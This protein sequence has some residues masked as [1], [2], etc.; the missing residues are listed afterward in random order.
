MRPGGF[1]GIIMLMKFADIV[2]DIT[3]K[4]VDRPFTYIIPEE[5]EEAVVPG[6]R[7]NVP[8]GRGNAL[9][10]GYVIG[11]KSRSALPEEKLKGI[12][13]LTEKAVGIDEELV[14]L[15][16]WLRYRYGGTLY[17]AL[18]VCTMSRMKVEVRKERLLVFTGT[19]DQLRDQ[20]YKASLKKYKARERLLNAFLEN[21]VIPASLASDRLS[22]SASTLRPLLQSGLVVYRTVDTDAA[23]DGDAGA[24]GN[25][26]RP[27]DAPELNG[28]QKEAVRTVLTSEK[29]VSV[30]FGITGS[31]KTEV[32][33]ELIARCLEAGKE[34]IVLIPEIALT[35]QTVMRFYRRFGNLIS[36]VHS[37]LS[38]GEKYERFEAAREGKIRVMIGPRSALFTP[39]KNLG[40]IVI[41]EFHETAYQSETVP[42]YD[43]VETAIKRASFSDAR[44]LLGSATPPAEYYERALRGEF[45]LI[46]LTER[47]VRGAVLPKVQLVDMREELKKKNRSIFSEALREKIREKLDRKEQIMLFLNRRGYSGAVSC[48]ACGLPVTCPHCSIALS[49]H[50][51]GWLQCHICGFSMPMVK[52]CPECGSGLIGTFGIGTEK[53]EEMVQEAFPDASVL[54]MDADT[55]TGKNGHQEIIRKFQEQ[56]ADILIGTQMIVK[57][58]D[59]KKVTLMGILAADLSLNVPDYRSAERTFQLLVQAEGRAGRDEIPGDC[60][61]QT[62]LPEHYAIQAAA[63]QDY[64]SFFEREMVFRNQMNYPPKGHLLSVTLSGADRQAVFQAVHELVREITAEREDESYLGPAESP[65]F[66]AKD[67]YRYLFYVKSR[68]LSRLL[69]VKNR[70]EELGE[71]LLKD[72]KIYLSFDS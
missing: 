8:F 57:G 54:R 69:K 50:R 22:I 6:V 4:Q 25:F 35:Y 36:V 9:R 32:Y 63:S 11:L 5:L 15:A 48:R 45:N 58:H 17:Q 2:V 38:R 3:S 53:V 7:V 16:I 46:R 66:K 29:T 14:S 12:D 37:R 34:A 56:E 42:R 64:E 70:L 68:E 49:Y 61:V 26:G 18:S 59:F 31:G 21:R 47:A 71:A 41:D 40:L 27:E 52:E 51:N 67:M 10:T 19:D 33:L 1:F 44:V 72:S 13:S 28:G 24:A 20:L 30:L 39:F 43:A 62:Y 55:T 60:I 23:A 65:L